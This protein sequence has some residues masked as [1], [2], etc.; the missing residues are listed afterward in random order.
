MSN[1]NSKLPTTLRTL[2]LPVRLTLAMFLMAA[3]IGYLTA[4]I[5]LHFAHASPGNMLPTPDDAVKVFH[6]S[7]GPKMTQLERLLEA[8]DNLPFNGTGSMR[9]A[10]VEKSG[11][12]K[13][14]IKSKEKPEAELRAEREGE[15][16]AMLAWVRAGA[17]K[18]AFESNAF[19]LPEA[20]VQQPITKD[21]LKVDEQSKEV[22][23]RTLMIKELVTVRCAGCHGAGGAAAKFPLETIEGLAKYN[24]EPGSGAISLEK[25][26]L[27]T[28]THMMAF[29]VLFGATGLLFSFTRFPALVR[30]IFGPWVLFFQVADIG[31]WWA[32]RLDPLFAKMIPITGAAVGLGLG[33]QLLG[34]LYDLFMPARLAD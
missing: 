29:A 4:L 24:K 3:G 6:G 11:D 9:K 12:W 1:L 30:G 20:L 34:G 15:R 25:L 27:I 5:Q 13:D 19:V 17:S 26:A 7:T 28:H 31:L 33:I 2:P 14:A 22:K 8:P 16:L 23:P 32:A 21:F 18:D 10:F